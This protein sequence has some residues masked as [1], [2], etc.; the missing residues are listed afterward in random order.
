MPI[1]EVPCMGGWCLERAGC[2]NYYAQ[3]LEPAERLCPAGQDWPQPIRVIERTQR[4][5]N[6]ATENA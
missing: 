3:G 6:E 4:E 2:A 5:Q 1:D